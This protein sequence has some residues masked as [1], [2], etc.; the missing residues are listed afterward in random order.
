LA[1]VLLGMNMIE[2]ANSLAASMRINPESFSP[3]QARTRI[4]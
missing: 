2:A 4:S 1:I 3:R